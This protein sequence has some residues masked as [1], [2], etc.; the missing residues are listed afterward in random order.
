M[1]F[2]LIPGF[3]QGIVPFHQDNLICFRVTITSESAVTI[4]LWVWEWVDLAC[5]TA[6]ET[7]C[8][9]SQYLKRSEW[10]ATEISLWKTTK[11]LFN[12]YTKK[13]FY[14]PALIGKWVCNLEILWKF[15]R[16]NA[17]ECSATNC[18]PL[19]VQILGSFQSKAKWEGST[20]CSPANWKHSHYTMH[21]L[22]SCCWEQM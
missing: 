15:V 4:E 19:W 8:Y 21:I 7:P 2:F 1:A 9:S 6:L 16:E 10:K 3:S 18:Q 12:A 5:H 14:I 20:P 17:K 13:I 22:M 11:L